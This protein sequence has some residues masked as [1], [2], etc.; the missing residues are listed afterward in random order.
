MSSFENAIKKSSFFP[1]PGSSRK[2]HAF[3]SHTG[4]TS[5]VLKMF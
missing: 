2:L 1:V 4:S 5:V 3:R